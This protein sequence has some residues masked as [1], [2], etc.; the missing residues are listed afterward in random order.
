[1]GKRKKDDDPVV[2]ESS[3]EREHSGNP[4]PD[5]GAVEKALVEWRRAVAEF[6]R[7][8][9]LLTPRT[10]AGNGLVAAGYALTEALRSTRAAQGVPSPVADE[11]LRR[12]FSWESGITEYK[13]RPEV[14]ECMRS[15][16]VIATRLYLRAVAKAEQKPA[17]VDPCCQHQDAPGSCRT[18]VEGG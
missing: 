5:P 12:W 7:S 11:L 16:L 2:S 4:P 6:D 10:D 9:S 1:M 13:Q 15:D 18:G 8:P 17:P 14:P 3:S